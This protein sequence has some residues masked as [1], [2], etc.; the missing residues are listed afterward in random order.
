MKRFF[1]YIPIIFIVF[2]IMSC[3]KEILEISE[4]VENEP[5]TVE[6]VQ[7]SVSG[8]VLNLDGESIGNAVVDLQVQSTVFGSTLTDENGYFEFTDIKVNENSTL[9]QVT[10]PDFATGFKVPI[11]TAGI[12]NYA[13]INVG[14]K[15]SLQFNQDEK[16]TYNSEFLSFE[17]Q[18]HQ[19]LSTTEGA[20]D[21]DVGLKEMNN[22]NTISLLPVEGINSS[23][24]SV[25][26]SHQFAFDIRLYDENRNQMT[27]KNDESIEANI[28]YSFDSEQDE[29]WYFNEEKARWIPYTEHMIVQENRLTLNQ[30]GMYSIT[31]TTDMILIQGQLEDASNEVLTFAKVSLYDANE[32]LINET[33]TN[34]NGTFILPVTNNIDG[35]VKIRLDGYEAFEMPFSN[36]QS[37]NL[38]TIALAPETNRCSKKGIT[39][40][41][42]WICSDDTFPPLDLVKDDN[43]LE[44]TDF[45]MMI[46]DQL[47]TAKDAET[48]FTGIDWSQLAHK[49]KWI[50]DL[51]Y[52]DNLGINVNCTGE[53]L[54]ID[55]LPPVPICL[56]NIEVS[57]MGKSEV[58]IFALD[59]DNGSHDSGCGTIV[60]YGIL[61]NDEC[62]N[63]SCPLELFKEFI[64]FSTDDIGK[65]LFISMIVTDNAGNKNICG[66]IAF[67]T[68]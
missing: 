23:S 67:I 59:L 43:I 36:S 57:L 15:Q 37:T 21:L 12:K 35:T 39:I 31:R 26:L 27:L 50:Y 17:L 28:D 62:P 44:F 45:K 30:L 41:L 8:Q 54:M 25:F 61:R 48:F 52:T 55:E 9:L 33:F 20:I 51:S 14:L 58:Q 3:E 16:I 40:T 18:S 22:I 64:T 66:A 2:F 11:L 10:H 60:E 53:L 7:S 63:D 49:D 34:E 6:L 47:G 29:L 38:G 1:Q 5:E 46:G 56:E 13:N 4:T 32:L 19:L 42:P 24:E 68:E 65:E